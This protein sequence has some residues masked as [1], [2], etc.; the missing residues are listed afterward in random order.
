MT[1]FQL[2]PSHLCLLLARLMA[3][4]WLV[5]VVF[6]LVLAGKGSKRVVWTNLEGYSGLGPAGGGAAVGYTAV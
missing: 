1:T 2:L 3:K 5:W 4:Y 6:G